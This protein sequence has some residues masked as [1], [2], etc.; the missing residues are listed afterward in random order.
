MCFDSTDVTSFAEIKS[1]FISWIVM[2]K[3][4]KLDIFCLH[5]IEDISPFP[6]YWQML[7]SFPWF[8]KG[9]EQLNYSK[10]WSYYIDKRCQS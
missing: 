2:T 6:N 4:V 3:S 1:L 8:Y 10:S 5:C 9:I 7:V